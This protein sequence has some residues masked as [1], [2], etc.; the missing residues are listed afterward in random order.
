MLAIFSL[1]IYQQARENENYDQWVVHTYEVLRVAHRNVNYAYDMQA[2]YR[3]YFLTGSLSF[4][5][6]VPT[7]EQLAEVDFNR[8]RQLVQGN[9]EQ[10]AKVQKIHNLFNEF[11]TLQEKH[12]RIYV[13]SGSTSLLVADIQQGQKHMDMLQTELE[14]FIS[15]EMHFLN[16]RINNEKR[17]QSYHVST[18]I[19]GAAISIIGLI[20]SNALIIILLASGA[21]TAKRLKDVEE[22]YKLV[23]DN[24]NDGLY[25]VD[26]TSDTMVV[27]PSYY[28]QLGLETDELSGKKVEDI[29]ELVHPEDREATWKNFQDYLSGAIDHYSASYRMKHKHKSWIW[30]LSRATKLRDKT[31]QITR[32]VGVHTDITDQKKRE[33]ELRELNNE[34]ESFTY[35]ASHDL[36]SP[37]VNLKGFS[38]EVEEGI[39]KIKRLYA[40]NAAK[41]SANENNEIQDVI[42]KDIDESLSFINSAVERMDLL[43][44]AILNLSRIG[45]RTYRLENLNMGEVIKRCLDTLAYEISA[46][47]T[48]VVIDELPNIHADKLA[49]E[50]VFSNI[51]DNAVKYLDPHRDG[52]VHIY[53]QENANEIIYSVQDNGRGINESDSSKVFDIFRRARNSSGVR[54]LGMGL[55][56]V[57]ATVRKMGGRI[58][59]E[60]KQDVGTTFHIAL[61]IHA[62][63]TDNPHEK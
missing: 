63:T 54:G 38:K 56:F 16:Q 32:V 13:S 36:R 26:L 12:R 43:T 33:D 29:L 58:W 14:S 46:K 44:S 31:G 39:G 18:I 25:D 28:Q 10:L 24:T 4:L 50:Q 53:A 52:K 2:A 5:Q 47:H 41:F 35:I 22:L 23:L 48:E 20:V 8:L 55:A 62:V 30:L 34:L 45:R 40:K 42:E 61:P 21:K 19:T 9:P 1:I 27:S 60:S 37:L 49:A 3:G 6:S 51:I 17:E 57:R 15:Y 59:F 11:K 7:N